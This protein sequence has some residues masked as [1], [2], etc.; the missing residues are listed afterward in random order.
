MPAL[1]KMVPVLKN[2]A[3]QYSPELLLEGGGAEALQLFRDDTLL[4]LGDS[5]DGSSAVG[6]KKKAAG[7]KASSGADGKEGAKKATNE[8]SR[9]DDESQQTSRVRVFQQGAPLIFAKLAEAERAMA[10]L[11]ETVSGVIT[12]AIE[13]MSL[14]VLE[15]ANSMNSNV[16]YFKRARAAT[17]QKSI[18]AGVL[19]D[20]LKDDKVVAPRAKVK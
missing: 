13:Q 1:G 4:M 12:P 10:V 3:R 18:A 2:L 6:A 14:S 17:R 7:S 9:W 19:T 8:D 16:T 20:S 5:G 15:N 11:S